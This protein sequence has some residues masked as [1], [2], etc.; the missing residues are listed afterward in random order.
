MFTQQRNWQE[1][2]LRD[3]NFWLVISKYIKSTKK[4]TPSTY[5]VYKE[6]QKAGKRRK[7]QTT[8]QAKGLPNRQNQALKSW[9]QDHPNQAAAWLPNPQFQAKQGSCPL[10]KPNAQGR[11]WKQPFPLHLPS[12]PKALSW[13]L[14]NQIQPTLPTLSSFTAWEVVIN[15]AIQPL[16]FPFKLRSRGRPPLT[17]RSHHSPTLPS[18]QLSQKGVNFFLKAFQRQ[19]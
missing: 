14:R 7:Q 6:C 19:T 17:S 3:Q 18:F 10:W 5:G 9:V 12:P 4:G 15:K 2:E 1:Q 11:D 16:K 8:T 13:A